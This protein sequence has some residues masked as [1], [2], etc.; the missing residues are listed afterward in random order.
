VDGIPGSLSMDPDDI[1]SVSVLKDAA[2]A[3]IYG[4]RASAGVILVTTKRAK[5]GTLSIDY[6][7]TAGALKATTFPSVV[8]YKRY[9][10]MINE[11]AWNES[12]NVPG[13]EYFTY[14]K[15]FIDN[16]AEYNRLD[17]AAYPICDWKEYLVNNSAPRQKHNLAINYGSKGIK[18]KASIGYEKTDALYNNR[19]YASINASI[20]NNIK[21][22]EYFSATVDGFYRRGI[23]ENTS[24]NPLQAAYKY[25]PLWSPVYPDGRISAGRDATNPYARLNYGGFANSWS[26]YFTGKIGLDFTPFKGLTITGVYAPTVSLSKGKTMVKQIPYYDYADP[27]QFLGYSRFRQCKRKCLPLVF[28]T[29]QLRFRRQIPVPSQYSRRRILTLPS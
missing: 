22:N 13:Q 28:R 19:S 18:S 1:E 3:S 27:T 23:S 29:Y 17:P 9:M 15:D 11:T 5:E 24:V 6:S 21:V 7:G 26:D 16:Y 14:S 8:N 2:S 4:A 10:E 20:N 12:M 25:G